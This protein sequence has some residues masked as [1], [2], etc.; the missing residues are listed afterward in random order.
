MRKTN[1]AYAGYM[2]PVKPSCDVTTYSF[3][4]HW[5][6]HGRDLGGYV[7]PLFENMGVKQFVQIYIKIVRVGWGGE[8]LRT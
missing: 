2:S 7:P 6:S 3:Y 8:E 1:D 5:Q 4:R